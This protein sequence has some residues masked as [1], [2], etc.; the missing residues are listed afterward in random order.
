M[1]AIIW[2]FQEYL[3]RIWSSVPLNSTLWEPLE[4]KDKATSI[5]QWR[6]M[7]V[8]VVVATGALATLVFTAFTYAL[9]RRVQ[10]TGQL[11]QAIERLESKVPH[12]KEGGVRNIEQVMRE[13]HSNRRL[14]IALLV[15]FVRHEVPFT[16]SP[17][18]RSK[19]AWGKPIAREVKVAL[20]VV[21]K[22]PTWHLD[23]L[24]LDNLYLGDADLEKARL[25]FSNLSGS[26]VRY[27]RGAN[28]KMADLSDARLYHAALS[29]ANL[30][31]ATLDGS[32]LQ[33]ATLIGTVMSYASLQGAHLEGANLRKAN[34]RHAVLRG[35]HLQGAVLR[36]SQLRRADLYR[37]DLRGADLRGATGWRLE[38]LREAVMDG[39]TKLPGWLTW[40]ASDGLRGSADSPR[41]SD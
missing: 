11:M 4:E 8:Q 27:L 5:A 14:A 20:T 29:D 1:I 7:I 34:L 22:R 10:A 39:R 31:R 9:G 28:L 23:P 17:N 3:P 26:R 37:A 12:V 38:Q 24:E 2:A 6:L 40:D 32:R 18:G 16:T 19:R 13:S 33:H 15:S 41:L 25:N 36:E 30:H 21:A 35:A